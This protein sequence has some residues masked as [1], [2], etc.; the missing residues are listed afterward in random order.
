MKEMQS[1]KTEGSKPFVKMTKN[2][3]S[4]PD[5]MKRKKK[6]LQNKYIFLNYHGQNAGIRHNHLQNEKE[7]LNIGK[8]N[9]GKT[10]E[11]GN[12]NTHMSKMK[13]KTE[14]KSFLCR[15]CIFKP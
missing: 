5:K 10:A 9:D 1:C 13:E 15:F 11:W 2:P 7:S 4:V 14:G 12:E 6:I 3:C 8:Q